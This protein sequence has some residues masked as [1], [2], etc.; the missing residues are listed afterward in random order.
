MARKMSYTKGTG[1]PKKPMK[2]TAKH[3]AAGTR[4][5]ESAYVEKRRVS[6]GPFTPR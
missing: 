6:K 5:G 4:P 1:K 3:E 2:G